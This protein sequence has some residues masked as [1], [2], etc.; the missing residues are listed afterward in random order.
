MLRSTSSI[1][2]THS[3]AI[4]IWPRN[5]LCSAM[6][7]EI[8]PPPPPPTHTHTH[9]YTHTQIHHHHNRHH[10]L[11]LILFHDNLIPM[12]CAIVCQTAILFL[13]YIWLTYVCCVLRCTAFMSRG[14]QWCET[15]ACNHS[16]ACWEIPTPYGLHELYNLLRQWNATATI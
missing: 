1:C 16:P 2:G 3:V 8:P 12:R 6:A 4:S 14:E 15:D 5:C 11:S 9:T 7:T 13:V 10:H